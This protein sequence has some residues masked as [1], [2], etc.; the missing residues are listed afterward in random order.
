MA[1][2]RLARNQGA[3]RINGDIDLRKQTVQ[4]T[5]VMSLTDAAYLA[6]IID[7]EGS[8]GVWKNGVYRIAAVHVANTDKGLM[9][10]LRRTVGKAGYLHPK[11][12]DGFGRTKP[13]YDWSVQAQIDV[14]SL[15]KQVAPYMVIKRNKAQKAI[16][17]LEAKA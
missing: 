11:L 9:V 15:L 7:G 6:G 13:C 16:E 1:R 4:R 5:K 12:D 8:V 2:E 17:F 10:W 3:P 14:L